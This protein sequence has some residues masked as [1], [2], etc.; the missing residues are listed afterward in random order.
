VPFLAQAPPQPRG[1]PV[2]CCCLSPSPSLKDD[3]LAGRVG[4]QVKEL[5]KLTATLEKDGLIQTQAFLL[6]EIS[7]GADPFVIATVRTNSKKGHSVLWAG[8]IIMSTI[9]V[10][11]T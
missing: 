4:L 3:D 9:N 8:N 11:A 1:T 10:S 7:E 6:P 2:S 5:N